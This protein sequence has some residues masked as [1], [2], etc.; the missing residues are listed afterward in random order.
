MMEPAKQTNSIDTTS[1]IRRVRQLLDSTESLQYL[2]KHLEKVKGHS[3][4]STALY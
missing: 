4:P 2:I 1:E 3:E